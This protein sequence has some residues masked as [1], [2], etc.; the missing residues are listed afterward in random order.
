[1]ARSGTSSWDRRLRHYFARSPAFEVV[2]GA[3]T[4]SKEE[5][6][7]A[8]PRSLRNLR[9]GATETVGYL[10]AGC[11]PRV[12]LEVLTDAGQILYDVDAQRREL[13][14]VADARELEQMGRVERSAAQDHLARVDGLVV[15][16][17][18]TSTPTARVPSKRIF[19]TKA[20]HCTSKFGRFMTGCRYAL[21]ALRRRPR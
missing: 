5:P 4:L 3:G 7:R 9:A 12:V 21:A 18:E 10:S 11:R 15:P 2:R 14:G 19:V 8:D 6:L 1:M 17:S 16:C 13:V 20:R